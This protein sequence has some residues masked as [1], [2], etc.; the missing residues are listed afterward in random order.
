MLDNGCN[1]LSML[2]LK[3][4]HVSKR[5]YS[6]PISLRTKMDSTH[7]NDV[8]WAHGFSN[9]RQL[10]CL[11]IILFTVLLVCFITKHFVTY[12]FF[13]YTWF[14]QP[15]VWFQTASIVATGG[16]KSLYCICTYHLYITLWIYWNLYHSAAHAA[17]ILTP[18]IVVRGVKVC[19]VAI[20]YCY[21]CICWVCSGR[22]F[23]FSHWLGPNQWWGIP[24]FGMNSLADVATR[25]HSQYF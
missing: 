4:N 17:D 18:I 7:H 19:A 6:W 21:C 13:A 24:I 5:G 9:N 25:N 3:L 23:N 14:Y 12:S 15:Y 11:F 2:G 16:L 20:A 10:D 8:T 22:I 1:Y